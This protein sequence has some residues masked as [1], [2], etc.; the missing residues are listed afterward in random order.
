M[1]IFFVE[2]LIVFQ[3]LFLK[4]DKEMPY[5]TWSKQSYVSEFLSLK[6]AGDIL[7][8][9]SPVTRTQKEISE[10]MAIMK[11]L[12]KI[13]IKSPMKY[14]VLDLCAGNALASVTAVHLLPVSY[15]DACD[16]KPRKRRWDMVKRF[17]Y[18]EIDIYD[19]DPLRIMYSSSIIISIHPCAKLAERVVDIYNQSAAEYLIMMPCCNGK[20]KV[21]APEIIKEKLGKYLMWCW[22]LAER[23]EGKVKLRQDKKC[24]S[25]KNC[26]IIARK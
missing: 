11:H 26:V 16:I 1:F 9:V 10:A 22:Q 3:N 19:F 21:D 23:C 14:A 17:S 12:R 6:C 18:F 5:K 8:V 15:A 13:T 7:N 2:V 25:P 20:L 24:L 4:K